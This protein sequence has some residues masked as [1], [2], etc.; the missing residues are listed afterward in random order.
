[1]DV[2]NPATETTAGQISIGSAADADE[3]VKAARRA[4]ASWS[5]SSRAERIELLAL[6][7]PRPSRSRLATPTGILPW[8]P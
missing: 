5:Q 4:F 2:E 7:K 1:M 3:A 8:G 6:S